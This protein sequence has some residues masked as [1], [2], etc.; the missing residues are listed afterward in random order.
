MATKSKKTTEG[1]K[2]SFTDF[3]DALSK[4]PGF[5][6]GSILETNTFSETTEWIDTGNYMQNAQI[7]GSLFGGVP[8]SRSLGL[9]GDPETGKTYMCL[10]IVKKA[11]E[12]GYHVMW[13]DT[14]G[15]IEKANVIKF[16]ID[17]T[18]LR[19]Q[20]IKTVEQF[21][22]F[23]YNLMEQKK[24]F[25]KEGSEFKFLVVIDSLGMLNTEKELR[26]LGEGAVKS[27][28]GIKAKQLR[29]LF[30]AITLDMTGA[31]IP[32]ICTNHTTVGGIGSYTGPTKESAGGDGPIF[33]MSNV[34]FY[35]KKIL[36]EGEDTK[37][38]TG[39]LI[40]SRPKKLRNTQKK[41]I[42][43]HVS[44]QGGMNP[45]VGLENFVSWESCGIEKGKIMSPKD[46]EKTGKSNGN[47]FTFEG[48][49]VDE[50]TG[51]VTTVKKDLVFVPSETGRWCVKHLGR[52]LKSGNELF[53]PTIFTQEVLKE[54]DE[55]VIKKEFLLPDTADQENYLEDEA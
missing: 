23:V 18:K 32:L 42:T 41:E 55:K 26:D 54:L 17:A 10:N 51:E 24:A 39:I 37:A 43:M 21:K 2:K 4:I 20:P 6:L 9:V 3:D 27:D 22:I 34:L 14:E 35:S 49:L 7:S 8:N 30:R 13:C 40:T 53:R 16:G 31:K 11:I 19:Y 12:Q 45:F 48:E 1:G 28:M 38:V 46:Y 44:F 47:L 29:G 25:D 5:E 33:A 36:R 50:E 15:A 52:S